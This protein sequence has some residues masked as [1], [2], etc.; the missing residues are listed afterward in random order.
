MTGLILAA[1]LFSLSAGTLPAEGASAGAAACPADLS[2]PKLTAALRE[3]GEVGE[4]AA[5]ILEAYETRRQTLCREL[6]AAGRE[7]AALTEMVAIRERDLSLSDRLGKITQESADRWRLAYEKEAD[8]PIA[9]WHRFGFSINACLT[10]PLVGGPEDDLQIS[11]AGCYGY[12][13]R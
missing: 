5:A 3:M 10:Y 8:R 4:D 12:R 11:A 2:R 13:F 1:A 9:T 6:E 7:I